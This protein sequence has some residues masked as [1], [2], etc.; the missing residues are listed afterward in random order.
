MARV[1][2]NAM[3]ILDRQKIA[4]TL[5]EYT[6]ADGA[7]D[8]LAVAAKLGQNP[9]E[10]YKTLVTQGAGGCYVFV[11]PVG[12]ELDLKKA[13]RTVG[14]KSIAMLHMADL[15]KTTG[16]VRGGC[17]PLGMKKQFPTVIDASAKALAVLFVS[18]GKIGAQIELAPADLAKA[19]GAQLAAVTTE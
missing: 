8:G 13:A 4:Y 16:Y 7:I 5:H 6:A 10:V 15:L 2:T 3:R 19:T 11:I 9:N 18:G 14:K 12:A 17:S 1:K